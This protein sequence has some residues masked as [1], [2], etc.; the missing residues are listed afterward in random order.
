MRALARDAKFGK[1]SLDLRAKLG[2]LADPLTAIRAL[3]AVL[4]ARAGRPAEDPQSLP[5][6]PDKRHRLRVMVVEGK[7][8]VLFH[9]DHEAIEQVTGALTYSPT[10]LE[11]WLSTLETR[12]AWCDAHGIVSRFLIAPEKHVVYS[13]KLPDDIGVSEDRPAAMLIAAATPYLSDHIIYPLEALRQ[14]REHNETYFATDTHWSMYGAFLAYKALM[15]SLVRDIELIRVEEASLAWAKVPYVGDLGVRFDPERS[16]DIEFLVSPLGAHRA[17]LQNKK[18]E[19]GNVQ[20]LVNDRPELPR[21][22][23][24][25]D[26]F[27]QQ[28]IAP[29]MESFSRLV[30]VSSLSMLYDLVRAERPDVVLFQVAE[31]FLGTHWTG[32]DIL[33]PQDLSGPSFLEFTGVELDALREA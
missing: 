16:E 6:A 14:G 8:G 23:L 30:I 12:K 2:G 13:D 18:F 32:R 28:L 10:Q 21:C 9:R 15:A 22:I 11:Q 7:D 17:V 29:L 3:G 20:V 5:L 19:R 31:R 27:A 25:R 26:S 24:F 33:M 4:R 1:L